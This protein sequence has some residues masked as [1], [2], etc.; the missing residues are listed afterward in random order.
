[1]ILKKILTLAD[2][3]PADIHCIITVCVHQQHS[4]TLIN[5]ILTEIMK[6]TI[7]ISKWKKKSVRVKRSTQKLNRKRRIWKRF[8][9]NVSSLVCVVLTRP[10]VFV[11]L[12]HSLRD[13][14]AGLGSKFLCPIQALPHPDGSCSQFTLPEAKGCS[15]TQPRVSAGELF[16]V[17]RILRI[18]YWGSL[19]FFLLSWAIQKQNS[20][21]WP[22]NAC[23]NVLS[24]GLCSSLCERGASPLF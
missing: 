4:Y 3:N 22:L 20:L 11:S 18:T 1:M 14:T 10:V 9:K 13:R 12:Y 23:K 21:V 15:L 2:L 17:F 6:K 24:S 16:P 8:W 19:R 7:S 5:L